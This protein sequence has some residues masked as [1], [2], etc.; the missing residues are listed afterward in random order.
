MY[1]T[2]ENWA[3][4]SSGIDQRLSSDS[5][6]NG[7]NLNEPVGG[8]GGHS[9][10]PRPTQQTMQLPGGFQIP[11]IPNVQQIENTFTASFNQNFGGILNPVKKFSGGFTRDGTDMEGEI[12]PGAYNDYS[13]NQ[14]T[15]R[16]P[17]GGGRQ[18]G[19]D[20]YDAPSSF[21]SAHEQQF[22]YG[23]ASGFNENSRGTY[24]EYS[25]QE[26]P[27]WERQSSYG[28]QPQQSASNELGHEY[29]RDGESR[30]GENYYQESSYRERRW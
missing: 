4:K 12:Q 7:R 15:E 19:G 23:P 3:R 2:V 13:Q 30:E 20:E 10:G 21:P 29:R 16:E 26:P 9:H 25:G 6:R 22:G 5:V 8:G 24:G 18:Y 1:A 11:G 28:H 14:S 27:A 17:L